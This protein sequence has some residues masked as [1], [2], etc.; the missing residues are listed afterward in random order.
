LQ[1]PDA[2][3][4]F[5]QFLTYL[6]KRKIFSAP[7]CYDV[8]IGYAAPFLME[9]EILANQPLHT[10]AHNGITELATGGNSDA[11]PARAA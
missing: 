4:R 6:L 5:M 1:I 7:F 2:V 3:D 10:V 8:V 9:P 11:S